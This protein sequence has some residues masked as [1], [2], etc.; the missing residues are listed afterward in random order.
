VLTLRLHCTRILCSI[1]ESA[2]EQLTILLALRRASDLAAQGLTL[3]HLPYLRY[4]SHKYQ[5]KR[6]KRPRGQSP[7]NSHAASPVPSSRGS[8]SITLPARPTPPATGQRDAKA[9]H[10]ALNRQLPLREGRK[11]AFRPPTKPGASEPDWI[12]AVIT[13]SFASD[14][15]KQANH[16]IILWLELTL[17]TGTKYR[18]QNHKKTVNPASQ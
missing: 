1:I 17:V 11:V 13:K 9:R 16:S 18:I 8:V 14:K 4:Y 3:F 10:Q 6:N 2:L 15:Q 5:D 7:S 12:L